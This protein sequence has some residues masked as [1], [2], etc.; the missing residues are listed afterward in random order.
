MHSTAA[1]YRSIKGSIESKRSYHAP[2]FPTVMQQQQIEELEQKVDMI[3]IH[4]SKLL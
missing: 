4:N 1:P 3:L 2:S